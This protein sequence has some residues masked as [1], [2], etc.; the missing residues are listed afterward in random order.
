[1]LNLQNDTLALLRSHALSEYP[2]E[3]CGIILGSRTDRQKEAHKIVR[4]ENTADSKQAAVHFRIDPLAVLEAELS[5][6][7]EQLE[8]IGFY[9]SHPDH[10]AVPSEQDITGMIAGCSYLIISVRDGECTD[11]RSFERLSQTE[12]NIKEE[13]IKEK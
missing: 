12:T 2:K 10:A 11:I 6:E 4:T 5:A 9:H 8:I 7:R 1:M 13:I 3:C